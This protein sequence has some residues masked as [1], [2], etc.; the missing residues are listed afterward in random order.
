VLV[1][2]LGV[3]AL[4][5]VLE[6]AS[7]ERF[8]G[9]VVRPLE[10][11]AI[12]G[13]G[14]LAAVLAALV[15]ARIAS[16]LPVM[17]ALSGR[18]GAASTREL[19][20]PMLGL[21]VVVGGAIL[22]LAT[23]WRYRAVVVD[24]QTT[25]EAAVDAGTP[26]PNGQYWVEPASAPY[27]AV[28]M[29]G[30]C[31]VVGGVVLLAPTLIA[32]VARLGSRL[33]L[34]ARLALRD[35]GRHRHRTAPAVCAIALVVGGTVAI[36]FNL[37]GQEARNRQAYT[38]Q[39]PLGY[40]ELH[41]F[42]DADGL[43]SPAVLE[44]A[45]AV[46]TALEAQ[47]VEVRYVVAEIAPSDYFGPAGYQQRIQVLSP[48]LCDELTDR[49]VRAKGV[50]V[51]GLC[52]NLSTDVLAGT[53]DELA[54]MIGAVMTP[55]ARTVLE[56]GG[57]V[58][59]GTDVSSE[60]DTVDLGVFV[61]ND[62][63]FD[64]PANA[65]L[66]IK[67][68]LPA[69]KLPVDRSMVAAVF[70]TEETARSMGYE[71]NHGML[72]LA[73]DAVPTLEQESRADAIASSAGLGDLRIDRGYSS[74]HGVASLVL[75]GVSGVITI[76]GIAMAVGLAAAEGRADLATL[77]AIGAE[78]RRRRKIA[79]AQAG[80]IGLLGCGL[81]LAL[82]TFVAVVARG[83]LLIAVW[84]VPWALIGIAAVGVPL[85][86]VSIAGAFTRSR[87]PVVRRAAA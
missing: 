3:L 9:L 2:A 40:G 17:A 6:A 79:M 5:P 78:P 76:C 30:I 18:Y 8:A 38:A 27:Q 26:P 83:A 19:R 87:L 70:V 71:I 54:A 49:G 47:L 13:F 24:F 36:G 32:W 25:M 48:P 20:R 28:A 34:A 33:P 41:P 81:G 7:G 80:V 10:L 86:A 82:G 77:G 11:L 57:A 4:T 75:A 29:G 53:P 14:V 12:A 65:S 50:G 64:D 22:A 42:V 16:R 61:A 74:G 46:A 60:E 63:T 44:R 55:A 56:R 45:E 73:T 68:T 84:V 37:A 15:P 23:A 66:A 85:L 72:L 52:N 21:V 43:V 59:L 35:A 51:D 58:L 69:V 1:G 39:I 67:H 62:P 31:L